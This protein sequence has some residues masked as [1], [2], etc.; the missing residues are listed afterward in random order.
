MTEGKRRSV[1]EELNVK[2]GAGH[3]MYK[4]VCLTVYLRLRPETHR[5]A[6][7]SSRSHWNAL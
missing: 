6:A 4:V 2:D 5:A 1:G 7:A 3:K